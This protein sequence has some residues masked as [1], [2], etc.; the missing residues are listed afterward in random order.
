MTMTAN[1]I[2][3]AA[4]KSDV[5]EI[6]RMVRELA[7]FEKLA[8][9]VVAT[10]TLFLRYGFGPRKRFDALI[11]EDDQAGAIGF[12]LYFFNFSTFLGQPGLYLEDLYVMPDYRGSGIGKQLLARLAEIAEEN[13]CGRMEWSVLDWNSD[14][15]D[16]YK[17]FG[18]ILMEDWKIC[19]LTADKFHNLSKPR[20]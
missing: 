8:H 7:D 4:Q 11:A 20:R 17:S 14:A 3:R 1:V 15:I 16:F 9:E 18:A 5:P 2:I 6:L 19:R 10:E 13:G 12:A